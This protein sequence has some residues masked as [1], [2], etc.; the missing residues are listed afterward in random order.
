MWKWGKMSILKLTKPRSLGV[1]LMSSFLLV[2][3][4][5]LLSAL[6]TLWGGLPS[7]QL[8][9]LH[10]PGE[11]ASDSSRLSSSATCSENKPLGGL[12]WYTRPPFWP[13]T[14]AEGW[15]PHGGCVEHVA[16]LVFGMWPTALLAQHARE[17]RWCSPRKD[18]GAERSSACPLWLKV[19]YTVPGAWYPFHKLWPPWLLQLHKWSLVLAITFFT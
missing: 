18:S 3:V 1:Q 9:C 19:L 16:E 6:L 12:A 14:T 17:Q 2:P 5:L 4:P 10:V 8:I 13:N 11:S 7:L 15:A